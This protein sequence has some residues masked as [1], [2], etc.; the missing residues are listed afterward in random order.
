MKKIITFCT[1]L[2][3]TF[4]AEAQENKFAE[5]RAANAVSL[6]TSNMDISD[7]DV[8][9]LKETLYNKYATNASKIRG[10]DLT[11]DEKRQIYRSA[12][13]ET[14]KKL[15]TVFTKDQVDKITEFEK[16]SFKK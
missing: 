12:F 4:F 11:D 2:I 14:R 5:K 10:K 16:M 13:K 9:F 6:I 1:I 7:A 3:F 15:M 8:V